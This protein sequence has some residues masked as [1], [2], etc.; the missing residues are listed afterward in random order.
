MKNLKIY[1]YT[2]IRSASKEFKDRVPYCSA[3]LEDD[4]GR[5]SVQMVEGCTDGKKT[6]IGK[7][8]IV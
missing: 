2:I 7:K 5:R 3:I 4:K 6:V 8:L 1:T